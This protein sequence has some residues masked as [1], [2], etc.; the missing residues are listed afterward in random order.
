MH[1]WFFLLIAACLQTGWIY[2]LK[3]LSFD[4]L[5]TL[6]W[7]ML[8]SLSTGLPVLLPLLGNIVFGLGN[9]YFFSLALKQMPTAVAF[10]VWTALVLAFVKLVDVLVFKASWSFTE[11]LF[12]TLIGL[13]IVGLRLYPAT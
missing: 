2:T 1:A 12:L 13:G 7:N 6:G 10:A 8:Y 5:K 3:Y 4:A 11:L 9:M